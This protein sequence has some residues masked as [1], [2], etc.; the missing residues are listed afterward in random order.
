[1]DHLRE[2]SLFAQAVQGLPVRQIDFQPKLFTHLL[3]DFLQSA[4]SAPS[5]V[6]LKEFGR[7]LVE[8][9]D[10]AIYVEITS[11]ARSE[12]SEQKDAFGF[13]ILFPAMQL[14]HQ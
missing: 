10:I 11:R 8:D 1:M 2:D 6:F 7:P 12:Y 3:P 5:G 9:V 4:A 14:I 13:Q